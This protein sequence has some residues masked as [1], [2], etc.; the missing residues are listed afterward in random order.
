M[1]N[2]FGTKEN[3]ELFDKDGKIRYD[4]YA[5]SNGESWGATYDVNGE[6]LTYKD[7]EGYSY[8]YTRDSIGNEL[9]YKDSNGVK[10]GFKTHKKQ[11]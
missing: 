2:V 8:K 3:L 1:K 10:R 11:S 4:Y 9:T 6:V 7:S 5:D